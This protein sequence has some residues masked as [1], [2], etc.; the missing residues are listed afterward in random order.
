MNAQGYSPSDTPIRSGWNVAAL[1]RGN[2]LTDARIARYRKLGYYS[3]AFQ[4]ARREF[5]TNQAARRTAREG[6]FDKV[7]GRLIFRP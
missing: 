2:P 1:P 3:A 6:N 7:D 4:S 5:W